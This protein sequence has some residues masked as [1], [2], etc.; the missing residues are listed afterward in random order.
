LRHQHL[1]KD[2]QEWARK[3]PFPN[4]RLREIETELVQIQS[5]HPHH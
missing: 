5:I 1:Q 3:Y 4:K 2:L